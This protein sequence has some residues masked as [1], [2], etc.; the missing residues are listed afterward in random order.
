MKRIIETTEASAMEQ[1]LGETV[2]LFCLNYIY[3]GKL[4]AVNES[5]VTLSEPR[6]VYETGPFTDSKY[7]D[8]QSLCV[9]EWNVSIG[10]IESFG[11]SK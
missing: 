7:K 9:P 5:T 10:A 6:I 1:L 4:I 8:A 11:K 3:T 2:L